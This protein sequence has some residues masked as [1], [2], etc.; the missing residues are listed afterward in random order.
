MKESKC[1]SPPEVLG[2]G[3]W[4]SLQGVLPAYLFRLTSHTLHLFFTLR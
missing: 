1:V 4:K 2:T 3:G